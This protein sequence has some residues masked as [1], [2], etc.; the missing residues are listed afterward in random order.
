MALDV[1]GDDKTRPH[2]APTR[3]DFDGQH[4]DFVKGSDGYWKLTNWYSRSLS[5]ATD[6]KGSEIHLEDPKTVSPSAAHWILERI[7]PITES[8]FDATKSL[9][10][11]HSLCPFARLSLLDDA[12]YV[13]ALN[14]NPSFTATVRVGRCHPLVEQ[15]ESRKAESIALDAAESARLIHTEAYVQAKSNAYRAGTKI[16]TLVE[17]EGSTTGAEAEKHDESGDRS[18]N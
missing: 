7:R 2:L 18:T 13:P 4:W 3:E 10:E 1:Y 8:G 15:E 5:L 12:G 6:A 9:L 16:P 14:I 11:H 17:F